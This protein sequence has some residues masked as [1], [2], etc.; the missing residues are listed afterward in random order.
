MWMTLKYAGIGLFAAV[1]LV[2][3][4]LSL[5]LVTFG[6]WHCTVVTVKDPDRWVLQQSAPRVYEREIPGG[7]VRELVPEMCVDLPCCS[8]CRC[9]R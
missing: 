8:K 7:E 1:I 2:P 5:F 3:M 4:L 9:G 6:L